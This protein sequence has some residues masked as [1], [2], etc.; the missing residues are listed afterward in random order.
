MGNERVIIILVNS[1]ELE[2]NF[3]WTKPWSLMYFSMQGEE[4]FRLY[5]KDGLMYLVHGSSVLL[6]SEVNR[7]HSEGL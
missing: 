2:K 4:W 5:A 7:F 3:W 1:V 6:F